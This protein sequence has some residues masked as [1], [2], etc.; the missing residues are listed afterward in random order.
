MRTTVHRSEMEVQLWRL[1]RGSTM[2]TFLFIAL[3]LLA[4]ATAPAQSFSIDWFSMDGGGGSSTGALYSVT[5]T[6]S[7]ADAGPAMSGANYTVSGG[8][9]SVIA[10]VQSSGGPL[11]KLTLTPTNTVVLSWPSPSTGFGFEANS[12][13]ATTSR[14]NV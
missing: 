11:L 4:H 3:L 10:A 12:D 1:E 6:I 2:K 5:G 13:L 7:Q 9:W 14:I 8:F